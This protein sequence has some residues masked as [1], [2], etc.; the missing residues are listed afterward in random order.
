MLILSEYNMLLRERGLEVD[1]TTNTS[2]LYTIVMV[3]AAKTC[4]ALGGGA[5]KAGGV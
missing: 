5:L 2:Y 1:T 4:H 3:V